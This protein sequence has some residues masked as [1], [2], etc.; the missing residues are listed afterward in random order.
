MR[1][2]ALRYVRTR[3]WRY[4]IL[5]NPSLV[6]GYGYVNGNAGLSWRLPTHDRNHGRDRLRSYPLDI[7]HDRGWILVSVI[8][9]VASF[10]SLP[11]R[12]TGYGFA[13]L[14]CSPPDCYGPWSHRTIYR[15]LPVC[16]RGVWRWFSPLPLVRGRKGIDR[17][18]LLHR[19][20]LFPYL[21]WT[22]GLYRCFPYICLYAAWRWS[23][24]TFS[25]SGPGFQ[26]YLL[27]HFL[28][29]ITYWRTG[30]IRN[31]PS[32]SPL[33][34]FLARWFASWSHIPSV[35]FP[36]PLF[37]CYNWPWS[38]REGSNGKVSACR[39]GKWFFL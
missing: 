13:R 38:R 15:R 9:P 24:S 8:F 19:W 14:A 18:G 17:T 6:K 21:P 2:F 5:C 25:D 10:P 31:D 32:W 27:V 29:E 26:G 28:L 37:L 34:G 16:V 11:H 33:S 36:I 22:Y 23:Y 4:Y 39:R 3:G 35:V 12:D 30:S 20:H 7:G 1:S